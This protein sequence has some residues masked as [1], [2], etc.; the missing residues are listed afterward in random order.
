[1]RRNKQG[2]DYRA[3]GRPPE[4]CETIPDTA[5]LCARNNQSCINQADAHKNSLKTK[6]FIGSEIEIEESKNKTIRGLKGIVLWETKNT[7]EMIKKEKIVK[8]LKNS[9]QKLKV[10]GTTADNA[11]LIKKPFER[12][13][14]LC[15]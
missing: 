9:I 4:K 11:E 10:N 6:D 2:R 12:K 15:N 3:S 7:L 8:L 14:A 1:M 5:R 13:G